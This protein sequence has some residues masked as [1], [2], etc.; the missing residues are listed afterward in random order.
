[1]SIES[2]TR[3]DQFIIKTEPRK[4]LNGQTKQIYV[5]IGNLNGLQLSEKNLGKIFDIINKNTI[6]IPYQHRRAPIKGLLKAEEK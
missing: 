3:S 2:T 1:M 6:N 4:L 5:P